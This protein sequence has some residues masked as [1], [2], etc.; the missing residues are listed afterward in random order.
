[1]ADPTG[2]IRNICLAGPAGAGKTTL[3]EALLV[4]AR[5]INTAGDVA[6]GTT[7]SDADAA[8]KAIG[9]S[10]DTTLCSF[11]D[12]GLHLNVIDT[13][14]HPD[15]I[16]RALAVLAAAD[17][18]AV[19]VNAQ[20]G[21]DPVTD[22]IMAEALRR[23]LCRLVVVNR[24]DHPDADPAAV[25]ASI[26]ARFGPE[27]LP[28]NLPVDRG[29]AVVDCF[30]EPASGTSD[31]GAID[32]A[33]TQIV[34]QVVELSEEL[35]ERYLEQDES[36]SPQQLHAAFEQALREGHLIPV[37][38]VSALEGIGIDYLLHVFEEL[39]PSPDEGNPPEFLKGDSERVNIVHDEAA[40]AIGHVFKVSIDPFRGRLAYVRVHQGTLRNHG[41]VYIGDARKPFKM[42]HLLRVFG[43]RHDEIPEAGPGDI[44]AIPRAE[45]MH[46][47]A[48][49]HD[50]HDEDQFHLRRVALPEPMFAYAI[51]PVKETEAQKLSD[52]LHALRD[53]D[54][55]IEI[56]HIG[57]FNETVLRCI[58][59][60]H[61]KTVL[62]RMKLQYN[63]DVTTSEPSIPYRETITIPAEGH[64]RHKK[65][66]GGAGQFGEVF[67]RIEPLPRGA[68]VEFVNAISGGVIPSQFIPAVEK[69]IRQAEA[70]G[71]IAGYPVR[72]LRV[73]VHDGKAHPVDS[74]EVA[75]VS[76]GRK[77]FLDAVVK[78]QP[79]VLE[80]IANVT[81]TAPASAMGDLSGEL[82]RLRGTITGTEADGNGKVCIAAQAPL[83][84][85]QSFHMRLKALSG[86]EGSFSLSPSHYAQVPATVQKALEGR[87]KRSDE[88]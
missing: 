43:A 75:F 29:R 57:A 18:V 32:A 15:L 5:V 27:C 49:V 79:I 42:S 63:V 36:V 1:M 4:R 23:R 64:H 22:A 68:G 25:F 59:E 2:S 62:E 3:L 17:S 44:C 39:M 52:A 45:G 40:H 14:G 37:V 26:Q 51:A 86:G 54:P 82:A 60:L 48:V 61:M 13:P 67:L 47:D 56:E 70:Q 84:E 71:A 16:G 21:L 55:S 11:A 78:A 10:L 72:D 53:E 46:Y 28:L 41:H 20:S 87:F 38:F 50:S 33:H 58:G 76:A 31:L 80:P 65:Q 83:A 12:S 69:G 77:A 85:M 74:K 34:E 30:F 35:M 24:I 66:T 6:H 8:E 9:H 7:V 73:T 88:D 81:I 19:V